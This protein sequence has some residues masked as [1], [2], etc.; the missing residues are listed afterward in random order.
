[1]MLLL[2]GS[3]SFA[4]GVRAATAANLEIH[5]T[6][7]PDANREIIPEINEYM[8]ALVKAGKFNDS[9]YSPVLIASPG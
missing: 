1:M 8:D 4:P 5:L 7:T 9:L 3:L 2:S 6:Q